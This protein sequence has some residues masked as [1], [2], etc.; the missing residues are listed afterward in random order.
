MVHCV[1]C[2]IYLHY[3]DLAITLTT[4]ENCLYLFT[5]Q[6]QD[7]ENMFEKKYGYNYCS[8]YIFQFYLVSNGLIDLKQS[9]IPF[10]YFTDWQ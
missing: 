2:M 3:L 8:Y 10:Y 5:V 9:I 4:A 1:I 6:V 7:M